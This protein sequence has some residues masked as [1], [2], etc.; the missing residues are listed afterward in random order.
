MRINKKLLEAVK[1]NPTKKSFQ[2]SVQ[3]MCERIDENKLTLPLYQRDVSWTLQKSVDLLNYQ[4][5][6]KAPV[7][8]ISIN[9]IEDV[10]TSVPQVSFIDRN[11]IDKNSILNAHLSVV[12]GQQRLTT[13]YKAFKNSN[14]F[15]NIVLDVSS[16]NFKIIKG[17]IKKYQIPVGILLNQNREIL[18][19]YLIDNNTFKDLYASCIDIRSKLMDYNY[20]INQADNLTEDEQIEWFEVLNN[21]GSKV[22]ALQMSFSKLKLHDFDI[23]IDYINPFKDLIQ[24]YGFDELFSPFTTNVSYPISSLN[25]AYEVVICNKKHKLN[26]API[27]SD[28]RENQLTNLQVDSLRKIVS[29]S[30]EGLDNAL[31]FIDKNELNNFIKRMDYILYL[32]GYFIFFDE[33]HDTQEVKLIEW[34]KNIEF[35]NKSNGERRKI[36]DE[37]LNII[38]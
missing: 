34:V 8:P 33:I 18:Q 17:E 25:P 16:A 13:N 31:K 6:G 29:L 28:T 37:L 26:F 21:A 11:L 12:D 19:N 1:Y 30:L 20:T 3:Q 15:R 2:M 10:E 4:L 24:S 38:N 7:A 23:Y 22:T 36:F 35:T 5:F 14:D 27:P 32:T 9:Q